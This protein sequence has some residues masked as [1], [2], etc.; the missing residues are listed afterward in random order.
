MFLGLPQQASRYYGTLLKSIESRIFVPAHPLVSYYTSALALYRFEA[1]IRK[2]ALNYQYRPFRWHLLAIARMQIG[3]TTVPPM[4]TNKFEKYC[5][6]I[7]DILKDEKKCLAAFEKATKVLILH[8]VRILR[9][10]GPKTP[11]C[12]P[13]VRSYVNRR[14]NSA[15]SFCPVRRL[16]PNRSATSAMR[17]AICC[18][19]RPHQRRMQ[20][21]K[22]R[23]L[24]ERSRRD[25]KPLR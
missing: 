2:K 25:G 11:R 9:G 7:V 4:A 3:G 19:K 5:D 22:P 16:W 6:G 13:H 1:L 12:Y 8:S 24:R 10:I 23:L 14:D 15:S 20:Y 17:S 21:A 18:F